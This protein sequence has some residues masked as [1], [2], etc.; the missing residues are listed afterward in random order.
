MQWN[1]VQMA[2]G[3]RIG[4]GGKQHERNFGILVLCR[5]MQ[6]GSAVFLGRIRIGAGIQ[7]RPGNRRIFISSSE[8]EWSTA[9]LVANVRVGSS[10]KENGDHFGIGIKTGRLV[11]RSFIIPIPGIDIGSRVDQRL[12]YRGIFRIRRRPGEYGIL[13][14]ADLIWIGAGG[15]AFTH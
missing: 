5:P 10:S 11:D 2:P 8:I 15:K 9:G 1:L 3:F 4:A 7:E 14:S 12:Q 13:E 6:R